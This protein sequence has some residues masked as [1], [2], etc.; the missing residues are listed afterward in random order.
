MRIISLV[1]ALLASSSAMA[2]KPAASTPSGLPEAVFTDTTLADAEG[3]IASACM[4]KG[5]QITTQTTNQVTCQ[6]PFGG[7]KQALAGALL[8]NSYS[9]PPNVF[10]AFSMAQVGPNVRVQARAW[11]ETQM[12]FGQVRTMQYDDS[13]SKTGL[14]SFL[15]AAGAQL[16]NGTVFNTPWI[17]FTNRKD[18][19]SALNVTHIF[20]GSPAQQALLAIGDQITAV[21]GKTFKSMADFAN[22]LAKIRDATYTLTV[23]RAA[24]PVTLTVTR[25]TVPAV[26]TPEYAALRKEAD[27]LK[28]Q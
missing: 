18:D 14:M 26:G 8:G 20:T 28:D 19:T 25:R 9:T 27:T 13:K 15:T 11:M 7:F 10:A 22:R 2:G 21:N 23:M 4:D 5:W 6:V 24:Q 12:A 1:A 3:K 17:G 16:P